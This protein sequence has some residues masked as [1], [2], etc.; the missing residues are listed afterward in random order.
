M[1]RVGVLGEAQGTP[2]WEAWGV[3]QCVGVCVCVC[4]RVCARMRMCACVCVSTCVSVSTQMQDG[5]GE[6]L[7]LCKSDGAITLS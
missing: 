7:L 3:R 6:Y 4:A 1:L 2:G 5:L